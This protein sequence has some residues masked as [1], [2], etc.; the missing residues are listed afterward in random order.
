MKLFFLIGFAIFLLVALEALY[1]KWPPLKIFI[2][3]IPV[4]RALAQLLRRKAGLNTTSSVHFLPYLELCNIPSPG[5][6]ASEPERSGYQRGAFLLQY[7][8]PT[9]LEST[10]ER[11]Q[12]LFQDRHVEAHDPAK[13][14]IFV[15]G[16]SVTFGEGLS[17]EDRYYSMLERKIGDPSVRVIPVGVNGAVSTQEN[18]L[19]HLAVLPLKPDMV[20]FINGWND[21]GIPLLFAARPGDPMNISALYRKYYDSSFNLL[22][23]LAK[24]FVFF[25]KLLLK[26]LWH[27][28]DAFIQYLRDNQEFRDGLRR[29]IVNIF[30]S[31]VKT[32]VESCHARG[33]PVLHVIQPCVEPLIR[34][35]K[36]L[37]EEER[38]KYEDQLKAAPWWSRVDLN[39]F[40]CDT[41]Y[42]LEAQ[43]KRQ[44]WGAQSISLLDKFAIDDFLDT[45][46]LNARGSAK[47]S[48]ELYRHC[49][50]AL[51]ARPSARA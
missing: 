48:D 21:I 2:D 35:L 50:H 44:P 33:I 34:D 24:N 7:R 36:K 51:I 18:L 5:P 47:L 42:E 27:D 22:L 39:D 1:R 13:R 16:A 26:R 23:K 25:D 41:L 38:K 31:N 29:S 6:A 4:L 17:V 49:V 30:L 28:R 20:I 43:T 40:L 37:T 45:A 3:R 12:H 14:R 9:V 19:L 46:H 8:L 10:A 15:V 32:M 11:F